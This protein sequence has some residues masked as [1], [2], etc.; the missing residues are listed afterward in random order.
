MSHHRVLAIDTLYGHLQ[1]V[2][3]N[4]DL[5]T[6]DVSDLTGLSKVEL[7]Q[8]YHALTKSSPEENPDWFETLSS[9]NFKTKLP[10]QTSVLSNF[11]HYDN[12]TFWQ[13][14]TSSSL[15]IN[16]NRRSTKPLYNQWNKLVGPVSMSGFDK[17]QIQYDCFKGKS[18][19]DYVLA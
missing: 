9:I 17:F 1:I 14:T 4:R 13:I 5:N 19:L 10:S 8:M 7:E 16:Y 12:S 11:G 3:A 2:A 6:S 15:D 18:T